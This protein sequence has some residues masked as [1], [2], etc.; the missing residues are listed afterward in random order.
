MKKLLI[1]IGLSALALSII[2]CKEETEICQYDMQAFSS[3]LVS[4]DTLSFSNVGE[5]SLYGAGAEGI[6]ESNLVI[7][8]TD[9]WQE[10]LEKI[11]SVNEVSMNFESVDFSTE[12]VLATFD[13][14]RNSGGFN[15]TF[16]NVFEEDDKIIVKIQSTSPGPGTISTAVITQPYHII[17]INKSDLEV[18]FLP[19]GSCPHEPTYQHKHEPTYQAHYLGYLKTQNLDPRKGNS[20]KLIP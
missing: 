17:K 2:S 14:I 1:I 7:T 16:T 6:S 15:R 13:P 8:S 11:D 12:M 3:E 5:S 19:L 4:P 9:C 18:E 20:L 10:L